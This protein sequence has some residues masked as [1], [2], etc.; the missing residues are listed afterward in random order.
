MFGSSGGHCRAQSHAFLG[1]LVIGSRVLP[2]EGHRCPGRNE[3]D[4]GKENMFQLP[5]QGGGGEASQRGVMSRRQDVLRLAETPVAP[6]EGEI[7]LRGLEGRDRRAC[8]QSAPQT[9]WAYLPPR[10]V[11]GC[12]VDGGWRPVLSIIFFP[13][14]IRGIPSQFSLRCK[15]F[16]PTS[17]TVQGGGAWVR[18][19]LST[20]NEGGLPQVVREEPQSYQHILDPHRAGSLVSSSM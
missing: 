20:D 13:P 18:G 7:L 4:L 10:E 9:T 17:L 5:P 11:V 12:L 3:E 8:V 19:C 1:Y 16:I 14:A 6:Q 15:I 2:H